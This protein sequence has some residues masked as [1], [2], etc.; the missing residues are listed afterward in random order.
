MKKTTVTLTFE[1]AKLKAV[2]FYMGRSNTSLEAELDDF[3]ARLYKK[4][5]PYQTREYIESTDETDACPRPRTARAERRGMS[6]RRE[7]DV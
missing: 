6:T 7:E 4:Y 5:V 2:Q 3:M 1:Q